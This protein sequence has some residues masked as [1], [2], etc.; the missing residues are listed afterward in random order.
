MRII[1]TYSLRIRS[2]PHR[3]MSQEVGFNYFKFF[4][5]PDRRQASKKINRSSDITLCNR[6]FH[7]SLLHCFRI[8]TLM[9]MV[10]CLFSDLFCFVCFLLLDYN[11][12][13]FCCCCEFLHGHIGIYNISYL[14]TVAFKNKDYLYFL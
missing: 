4:D 1:N 14:Y 13:L 6:W 12:Q 9:K 5:L 8:Q 2:K 3:A 11:L 10:D 7:K